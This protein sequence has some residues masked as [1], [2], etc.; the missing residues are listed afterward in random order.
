MNLIIKQV[1]A[2]IQ[3]QPTTTG[4]KNR[5]LS[6]QLLIDMTP[7]VYWVFCSSLFSYLLLRMRKTEKKY[8][9]YHRQARYE[10]YA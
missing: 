1:M 10:C 2:Q 7:M 8:Y 5:K 3:L 9:S 4:K 6:A